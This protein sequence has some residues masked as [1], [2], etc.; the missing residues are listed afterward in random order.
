MILYGCIWIYVCMH[1]FFVCVFC[2]LGYI[3]M[4]VRSYDVMCVCM[5]GG[6]GVYIII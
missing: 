2:M 4:N 5:F 6:F 3:N 1:A